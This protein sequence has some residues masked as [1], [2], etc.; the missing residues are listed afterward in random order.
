VK[1]EN[2][3]NPAQNRKG[4]LLQRCGLMHNH[5]PSPAWDRKGSAMAQLYQKQ[6]NSKKC[7]EDRSMSGNSCYR[8]AEPMFHTTK[9]M[10][11]P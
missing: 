7:D 11:S 8:R 5:F 4:M 10:S 6:L 2:K 1:I 3:T 9:L